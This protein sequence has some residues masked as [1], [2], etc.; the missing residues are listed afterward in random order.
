MVAPPGLARPADGGAVGAVAIHGAGSTVA[1]A[2]S[3]T[4]LAHRAALRPVLVLPSLLEVRDAVRAGAGAALLPRSLVAADLAMGALVDWGIVEGRTVEGWVLHLSR[5]LVSPKVS[6]FV[7]YLCDAF[8][9]G[10]FRV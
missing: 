3:D 8:P 1:W 4:G 6:A 2:C 10:V 9:E 5:R 7:S